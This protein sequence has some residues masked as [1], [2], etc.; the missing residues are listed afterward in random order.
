MDFERLHWS[1]RTRSLCG[2]NIDRYR[3]DA[4]GRMDDQILDEEEGEAKPGDSPRALLDCMRVAVD[5]A[6]RA[7]GRRGIQGKDAM[8]FGMRYADPASRHPEKS[9]MEDLGRSS[10][11]YMGV[12]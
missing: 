1:K 4:C 2:N 3:A 9:D 10:W 6:I 7:D 12:T 8:E 11:F 5:R